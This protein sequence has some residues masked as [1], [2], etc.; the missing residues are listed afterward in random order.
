MQE[1]RQ[2]KCSNNPPIQG[3]DPDRR[4]ESLEQLLKCLTQG[5]SYQSGNTEM[6]YSGVKKKR[7]C[8]CDVS[9]GFITK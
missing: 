7:K 9:I 8:E 5:V 3:H 1:D 4:E 2:H 6:G